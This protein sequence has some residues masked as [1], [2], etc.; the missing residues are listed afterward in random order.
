MRTNTESNTFDLI[1][2]G[3]G[4]LGT[5]H[6]YHAE[7]RGL[8]VTLVE[9]NSAPRDATV[10]N[11]GQVVPS[12]MDQKWQTYGRESLSVYKTIQ[13]QFDISVRNQGSIYLASD[14]EELGLLEELAKINADSGYPSEL[15][16]VPQCVSRYPS[17]RTDYCRGGLYFPGEVSVN[18]RQMIHRLHQFLAEQPG[19]HS[20]FNTVVDDL[21]VSSDGRVRAT[22]TSGKQLVADKAI[23]CC[24]A[25]F[26]T[27][28]PDLF[29]QSDLVAVKLQM[30]RLRPIPS[31]QLPGNIL[32]GLSIRRY[33][34]FSECPSWNAVKSREPESSFARQ[35][36]VHILFKQESDGG[37]IL[38]DSHEYAPVAAQG[39]LD[40]DIRHQVSQFF[41]DEAKKIF[42]LPSWDIDTAWYGVYGQTSDPSGIFTRTIDDHI[43]IT[44]GIG[45]KE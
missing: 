9:R 8:K 5:F 12:G 24:G 2:V 16:T 43:H 42:D 22:T 38:G 45:E 6:A 37:I 14:E 25:E 4:V 13:D 1:V 32:T 23:V 7:R 31:V 39:Q 33:E 44:T 15:W 26:K 17:L 28:F 19:F 18:P 3:A 10:R 34:S 40:F 41:V 27:L 30:L 21:Q 36:G 11:F 35:W 29:C 20:H